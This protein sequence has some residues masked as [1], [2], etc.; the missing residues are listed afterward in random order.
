[1]WKIFYINLLINRILLDRLYRK[2]S[3][4]EIV[5]QRNGI[6][7]DLYIEKMVLQKLSSRG[8]NDICISLVI[9][10]EILRNDRLRGFVKQVRQMKLQVSV[11]CYNIR[12]F[13]FLIEIKDLV[14]QIRISIDEDLNYIGILDYTYDLLKTDRNQIVYL[15]KISETEDIED[16]IEL[17]E[18]NDYIFNI[19]Y[20]SEISKTKY[21]EIAKFVSELKN[22]YPLKIFQEFTCAGVEY[23]NIKGIC[24]S[25]TSLM[26]VDVRGDIKYCN[27]DFSQRYL[28]IEDGDLDTLF[29]IIGNQVEICEIPRCNKQAYDCCMGGCPLE[30]TKE[31]NKF[32]K[33]N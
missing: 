28:H 23:D 12:N 31:V 17:L 19:S 22:R 21:W 1:M 15:F 3:I 18:D 14:G 20:K 25:L 29:T 4:L 11:T 16:F 10:G 27:N 9:D 13:D 2:L 5:Y 33:F 24:P 7:M 26:C 30:Q 6:M 32:C 8:S